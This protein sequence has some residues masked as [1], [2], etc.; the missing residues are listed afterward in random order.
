MT[1]MLESLIDEQRPN[2]QSK[3]LLVLKEL[4]RVRPQALGD[5]EALRATLAQL[6]AQ[7]IEE[8]PERGDVYLASRH[9]RAAEGQVTMR[10]LFRYRVGAGSEASRG[11]PAT[12]TLRETVLGHVGAESVIRN[13]GGTLT[14]D[15]TGAAETLIVID[16]PA[17]PTN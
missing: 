14:I 3:R 13:Q 6:L 9:H 15:T 17:P 1:A 12:P 7:A 8:V 2:I 10:V 4:D 16:L 11:D 5:P